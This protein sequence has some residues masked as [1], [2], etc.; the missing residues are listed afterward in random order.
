MNDIKKGNTLSSLLA[1]YARR[2]ANAIEILEKLSELYS[3]PDDKV[4]IEWTDD[5]DEIHTLELESHGYL[6]SEM[7][8]LGQNQKAMAGLGTR[9][10]T[11]VL[12]DGQRKIIIS[13]EL[14]TEPEPITQIEKPRFFKKKNNRANESLIDPYLYMSVNMTG[15]IKDTTDKIMVK[16]MVLTI[17]N[18]TKLDY[19]NNS[20]SNVN[21]SYE[22][23]LKDLVEQDITNVE[24][25]EVVSMPPK[26]PKYTGEFD[27]LSTYMKEINKIINNTETPVKR[28]IF[29]LNKH[30]YNDVANSMAEI[31]LKVGDELIV[32]A[33]ENRNTVY[34]IETI[35]TGTNEVS[36]IRTEGHQIVTIGVGKLI[37]NSKYNEKLLVDIGVSK[38]EYSVFFFKPVNP[39]MNV[40]NTDWGNGIGIYTN[41]LIDFDNPENNV[42]LYDF[43]E[44][45]V[46]NISNSI[47][48]LTS[49]SLIPSSGA[50]I[51]NTPI[52]NADDFT[53]DYINSHKENTGST[54]SLKKKYAEKE[55]TKSKISNLDNEINN[56]KDE[57]SNTNYKN[58]NERSTKL[59]EL[60]VLQQKKSSETTKFASLVTDIISR[61]KESETF[62]KKYRVRAF[63]DIPESK[64]TDEA[65]KTGEQGVIALETQYRYLK[66]DN[67][68]TEGATKEYTNAE[69]KKTGAIFSKWITMPIPKV[70]EKYADANGKMIW[71]NENPNDPD[72]ININQFEIPISYNENVEIRTRS[73]SEAGWP[74]TKIYSP[75]SD[76]IIKEFPDELI[77][78]IDPII[79]ETQNEN[80]LSQLQQELIS[81]GLPAHVSDSF[82]SGDALFK[83]SINNIST[84]ELT[85]EN[86]PKSGGQVIKELRTEVAQLTALITGEKGEISVA[87]T[88]EVGEEIS[89]IS[90]N[91][92]TNVFAGYYKDIVENAN[93]KKGEIVTKLYY[94]E[95]SNIKDADLELLSFVP[96]L[97]SEKTPDE[98]YD[99]YLYNS[100]EY[101]NYRKYWQAPISLRAIVDND[102]FR[103]SKSIGNPFIELPSYQSSQAK[104]QFVYSRHRDLT[105]NDKLFLASDEDNDDNDNIKLPIL[106]GANNETFIWNG[107]KNTGGSIGDGYHTDFCVHINHPDLDQNSEYMADWVNYDPLTTVPKLTTNG[108]SGRPY[109]PLFMQSKYANLESFENDGLKQLGY[110]EYDPAAVNANINNFP[111]KI[112]FRTNDK[113]LIGKNTVGSYLFLAPTVHKSLYVSSIIYN[114]GMVIKKGDENI[115]RIPIMYQSRMTDYFGVGD[116]GIGKIG[117]V[118][119]KQNLSYE[120]KIGFDVVIKN[121]TVFS[122]DVKVG[123]KY[124]KD[125]IG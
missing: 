42:N 41:E 84:D 47:K 62:T 81:Q 67:S 68:S 105:L 43:F 113:Y 30:T 122:F 77:D 102:D 50:L 4:I 70:R 118:D 69:G 44:E 48:L 106:N 65:N 28:T 14:P 31:S 38:D 57:I 3:S 124:K 74:Y 25:D 111:R 114:E 100:E 12:P 109:Y 104:G 121:Q 40:I 32:S 53:I 66:K 80:V 98:N 7:K 55:E 59:Q 21:V 20:I 33:D 76:S 52:L 9:S 61:V 6:M 13:S 37:I 26:D 78:D 2:E 22:Q 99:G 71:K 56:K 97:Y 125:S 19:F 27:V 73:I 107:A 117:G 93:I 101:L 120:K 49:E 110:K 115:I 17:D 96:G 5:L 82:I 10:A 95:I 15:K 86:K 94:I 8:R 58:S 39:N 63:I 88:D 23:F 36:L 87:I 16:R 79:Q 18:T 29:K 123:M 108:S 24:Y 64:Y 103:T 91:D 89:K 45:N 119:N 83:H 85:P 34:K 90:N 116:S 35:D 75:W 54:K 72:A 112:G 46:Q 11:L 1:E 92:T 51:P 60:E